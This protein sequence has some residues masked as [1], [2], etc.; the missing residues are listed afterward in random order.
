M[1]NYNCSDLYQIVR[2]T[3]EI[4][5]KEKVTANWL[6]TYTHDYMRARTVPSGRTLCRQDDF[7]GYVHYVVQGRY[8]HYRGSKEGKINLLSIRDK[9]DW[10][11]IDRIL[12][13]ETA[14]PTD[15]LT[16]EECIVL[17]IK[18][19]YFIQCIRESSDFSIY[20]IKNLLNKL[21]LISRKSDRMVFHNAK[22]HLIFYILIYWNNHYD[23]SQECVV[24]L[25]NDYIAEDMGI[26]VRTLYRAL[27]DLKEDGLIKIRKRNIVVNQSQIQKIRE[28]F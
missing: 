1:G 21:S 18:S 9:P 17:D 5:W 25:K 22:E 4:G 27:N 2:I 8:F 24:Q 3:N 16:L 20:I 26:C 10:I 15:N 28:F 6:K 11:G 12:T 19:E 23:G 13:P 14:N 7:E